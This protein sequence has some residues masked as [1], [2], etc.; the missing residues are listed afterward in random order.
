[1]PTFRSAEAPATPQL[2]DRADSSDRFKW[3]LKHIFEDLTSWKAAYDDLDA[4]IDAYAALQGTLAQGPEALLH[5]LAL[6]D[7]IGQLTYKD[8]KST[9]LN[10][11]HG[12]LSRMPSS[13]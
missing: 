1:M 10:S 13:A 6:S 7:A 2:R 3:N 11:S 4:K 5:A 9:R 12:T 8:R